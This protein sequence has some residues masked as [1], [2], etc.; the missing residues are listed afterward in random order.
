MLL[1]RFCDARVHLPHD[2]TRA[3]PAPDER[4]ARGPPNATDV[5]RAQKIVMLQAILCD[6]RLGRQTNVI[7]QIAEH[8][9]RL[10]IRDDCH[11]ASRKT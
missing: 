9:V 3:P 1:V 6:V 7:F 2:A 4:H 10:R 5:W 11:A 8:D